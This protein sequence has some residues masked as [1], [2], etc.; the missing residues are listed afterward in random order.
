MKSTFYKSLLIISLFCSG[1]FAQSL[2]ENLKILE[3]LL[4]K[5][6]TGEL[7]SPDGS[8][9]WE[10]KHEFKLL[11]NGE[12][13]KFS[14]TTPE[15]NSNAEGF[16]YYDRQEQKIAVMIINDKGIYQKGYVTLEDGL[17][18]VKGT[19][20]FPERTFEYKNTFEIT[21]EGKMIDR[22]Y[23]NAFGPWMAGHVIEF[24]GSNSDVDLDEEKKV[25]EKVLNDNIGWALEKDLD[26][27]Y[28]T[29]QK[30]STLLIINPDNSKID[31]FKEVE[32]TAKS[33]WMDPRF[34]ATYSAVK[35]LR[36]TFS[37]KGTVAWYYCLLDDFGEWNGKPYKWENARWTGTLE[38]IDNKWVIRQMHISFPK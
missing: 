22:W 24:T 8:E 13:I 25:I 6:W 4:Y 2:S 14:A 23:Q 35:N 9:S 21:S 7:K 12:T 15:R 1:L 31:G 26:L 17:I 28:S 27:L 32:E 36:V 11:W 34:K 29:M 18:T 30:D 37:N 38:K 3:P 5:Q 16:Y 10:T 19:I 33:F 20:S